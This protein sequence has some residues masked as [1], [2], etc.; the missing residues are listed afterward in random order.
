DAASIGTFN[1]NNNLTLQGAASFRIDKTGGI[2]SND[3][4][5]VLNSVNY[6]GTLIIT[7]TTS[8]ATPLAN[9]DTFTLFT[10]TP[11]IGNFSSIQGS[12]GPGLTYQFQN[13]V[14]TVL[15]VPSTPTSITFSVSAN[16]LTIGWPNAYKGWILQSQ[17]NSL[18]T[19]LSSNWVDV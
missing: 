5:N 1:I 19:G 6:G 14:L 7:N 12:P 10:A 4:I 2:P 9:G 13:G 11:H 16:G 17:T 3:Q 15:A 8:D 18:Q